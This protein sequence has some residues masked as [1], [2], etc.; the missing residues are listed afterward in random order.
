MRK[1]CN[2]AHLHV[3]G[4][5]VC[6]ELVQHLVHFLSIGHNVV[7]RTHFQREQHATVAVVLDVLLAGV[8]FTSY[9]G[10]VAQTD[11]LVSIAVDN[12]LCQFL[13]A[14]FCRGNVQGDVLLLSSET[15]AHG[16]K[17]LS[18]QCLHDGGL[19]DAIGC[20]SFAV[21]IE[22][23]LFLHLAILSH[24]AHAG[25]SAQTVCQ[26]VAVLLQFP[27]AALLALYGDEQGTGIAE[28]FVDDQCQHTS[29]QAALESVESVFDFAPHLVFLV[30]V[31]VHLHH[32]HTHS[33][34]ACGGGFL[35]VHFLI[36]EHVSFQWSCHLCFNFLACGSGHH[37]DN[38][39][40]SHHK[41]R[42]FV[43]G[44]HVESVHSECQ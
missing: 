41:R 19:T 39:A 34:A 4:D 12:L 29:R 18:A 23:D 5:I 37:G 16:C 40:L 44:H 3:F 2:A 25:H 15:S 6:T 21:Y 43:L 27:I 1:V 11:I 17:S 14:S 42:K 10:H 9:F 8:I 38:H 28:V 35:S 26:F 31:I 7:S 33:V 13:F 24:I 32:H 36:C 22:G 20:K 30:D